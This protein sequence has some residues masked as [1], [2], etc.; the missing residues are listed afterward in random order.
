VGHQTRAYDANRYPHSSVDALVALAGRQHGVVSKRQL[1]ELGFTKDAVRRRVERKQLLG[2][3]DGVFAVGHA[4]LTVDSRRLAAVLACG[5]K[6]LLSHRAAAS[7]QGLLSSSPQFDVTVPRGT[8]PKPGIVI[9]RSRL[10]HPEDRSTVRGI[11]VTSVARTL[12]D[13]ADVLSEERLAKSVHEAE[14]LRV[15]DLHA[16][17]RTL[18]RLPGRTGRHRLRRVLVAYRP[19]PH[20]TRSRA[21][22]RFLALCERHDLP[23]PHTNLWIAGYEVDAYWPDMKLAVEID[24]GEAHHTR[25]A[26]HEDRTRDRR[27]AAEGIQVVR[28]TWPDFDGEARLAAELRAI[29]A[30]AALAAGSPP[31]PAF[32]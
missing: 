18:A 23:A 13:L 15:L 26:F 16:I 29:R 17:E 24:G 28:V 9:H 21:E 22:R 5:P 1:G 27:L 4:A 7:A 32:A 6:A 10:I 19:D 2:L 25:A 14:V 3:H 20:F 8:R 11:P 30:A 12:V 31:A